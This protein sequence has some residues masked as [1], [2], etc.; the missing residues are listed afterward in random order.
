MTLKTYDAGA[1]IIKYDDNKYDARSQVDQT[2]SCS[3]IS[4][5]SA[6]QNGS[7]SNISRC[8][9]PQVL[10]MVRFEVFPGSQ[11]SNP[12]QNQKKKYAIFE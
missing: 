1:G 8:S 6:D 9:E 2:G 10:K 5:F 7:F 4:R 11:P 3:S 12:A